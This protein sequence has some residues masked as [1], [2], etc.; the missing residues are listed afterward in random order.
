MRIIICGTCGAVATHGWTV[1]TLRPLVRVVVDLFGPR[2]CLFGSD[3][4]VAGLHG[5]FASHYAAMRA[6]LSDL[7]GTDQRCIFHDNA[8]RLYRL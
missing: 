4:P 8:V 1:G 6:A 2:R 7:A 3:F 5:S